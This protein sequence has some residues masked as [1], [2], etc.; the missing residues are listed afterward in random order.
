MNLILTAALAAIA[1]LSWNWATGYAPMS[2]W[3]MWAFFIGSC[4][5]AELLEWVWERRRERRRRARRAAVAGRWNA[6]AQDR[7]PRP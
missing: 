1:G 2:Y 3:L 4:A 6:P 7:A 5:G